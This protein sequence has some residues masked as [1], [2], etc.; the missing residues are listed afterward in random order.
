[1]KLYL[2]H[3]TVGEHLAWLPIARYFSCH[4]CST[5]RDILKINLIVVYTCVLC[6]GQFICED[7]SYAPGVGWGKG[8]FGCY[9][10]FSLKHVVHFHALTNINLKE[11]ENNISLVEQHHG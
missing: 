5:K 4:T 8:L 2:V 11:S 1:M 10:S 3:F 6:V 9:R 7:T